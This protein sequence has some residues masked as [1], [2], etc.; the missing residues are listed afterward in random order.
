MF[1]VQRCFAPLDS[2]LEK[3]DKQEPDVVER[4]KG[5]AGRH[6]KAATRKVRITSRKSLVGV[7]ERFKGLRKSFGGLGKDQG[8]SER[9]CILLGKVKGGSRKSIW[10]LGKV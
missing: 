6:K 10:C 1:V 7:S 5:R 2:E 4:G 3:D 9:L 8:V